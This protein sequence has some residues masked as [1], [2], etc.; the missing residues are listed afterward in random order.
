MLCN[1]RDAI[2]MVFL[3]TDGSVEDERQ[4]CDAMSSLLTNQGS[5]CPR[6]HT[7]GIGIDLLLS[8]NVLLKF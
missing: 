6:V 7:F 5:I 3:I 1:T 8:F 4:I 2:P